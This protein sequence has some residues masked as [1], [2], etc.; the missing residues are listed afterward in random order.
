MGQVPSTI[1]FEQGFFSL[2]LTKSVG[3]GDTNLTRSLGRNR[4]MTFLN[5]S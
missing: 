4:G 3:K 2:Q 1:L 5:D